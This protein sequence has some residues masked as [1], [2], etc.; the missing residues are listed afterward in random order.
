M[1]QSIA[2][3]GRL[4][5]VFIVCASLTACQSSKVSNESGTKTSFAVKMEA[6]R[7]EN[8]QTFRV[9]RENR[10]ARVES[11]REKRLARIAAAHE[12]REARAEKREARLEEQRE[13]RKER[14]RARL[15]KQNGKVTKKTKAKEPTETKKTFLINH[16]LDEAGSGTFSARLKEAHQKV[17]ERREEVRKKS[18]KSKTKVAKKSGNTS[19]RKASAKGKYGNL[20]AKYASQHG[21]PYALARAVVQVESTFRPNVTGAAGEIGLMQIRLATARGMG[22]RGSAKGLYDPATNLYWGMKYLG[23]AH[24]LAGG[25][26]CGTILKYNAGHGA[27]R[28]NP[29]SQRYCNRVAKILA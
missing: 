17:K 19:S 2:S 22:Y 21:V 10:K 9:A 13:K 25:S 1:F 28:M 29:I 4:V 18:T 24:R 15:L 16:R 26:T 11:L 3:S 8:I 12:K 27:K 23:K 7:K 14:M 5:P 20:I 6:I